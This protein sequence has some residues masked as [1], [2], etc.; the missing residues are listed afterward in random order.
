MT[1]HLK[2][3]RLEPRFDTSA[4]IDPV[5]VLPE[6]KVSLMWPA[7]PKH[8]A[9]QPATSSVKWDWKDGQL[10]LTLTEVDYHAAVVI[11]K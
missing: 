4:D 10:S 7:K 2:G 9:I 3:E 5:A 8:V 11:K 1:S 6:L